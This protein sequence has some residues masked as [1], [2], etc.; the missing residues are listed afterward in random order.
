MHGNDM[1]N[2]IK[3]LKGDEML[4]AIETHKKRQA[5]ITQR[6]DR[7]KQ[8]YLGGLLDPRKTN[9]FLILRNISEK[10]WLINTIIG[11]IIDKT[12]PYL[13][14]MTAKSPRGFSIELK[15]PNEKMTK[16]NMKIASEIQEFFLKTTY[17]EINNDP[18]LSSQH[19]DDLI[20]YT[21]KV[22]R[23][24]LTIDQVAAEKLWT[25]KG[26]LLAFEAIDAGT[27]IRCTEE[28][29]NGNDA[30]RFVQM[31]NGIVE[32]QY[33]SKHIV[34]QFQ[35]PRTDIRY[36]GYGYSKIEQAIDLVVSLI[37]SFAYNAGAFTED[38]LPRGMLLLSGDAG[39]EEIEEIEDYLI[40]VM[41]PGGVGPAMG[42]W[43]IP[44]IPSG[45]EKGEIKWQPMGSTN[46]DMEYSQWTE[47]LYSAIGAL[48]GVDIESLGIKTQKSA[49]IIDSGSA[50]ARRYSDDKGIGNA[51]TFLERHFQHYLD[52]IDD[53][54][55]FV[56]HG[57]EKDDV[58]DRRDGIKHELETYK[59]INDILKE[60]D[61]PTVDYEWADVPGIHNPQVL[62]AYQGANQPEEQDEG[63]DWDDM[64]KSI[65]DTIKIII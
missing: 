50:D 57:F 48:Y 36:Y 5:R 13:R 60:N 14:P 51:L 19:E 4:K 31:I 25:R 64:N 52:I 43:G 29:Y 53:R 16:A 46:K 63:G 45:S 59:S 55:T 27:I 3:T 23:D 11:H 40:D 9:M 44:I 28:G 42:K 65:E 47:T 49:K 2:A 15:D 37:N 61:M 8:G 17:P 24:V 33:T 35:N 22:L 30:I 21:K 18:E 39:F 56:F 34:F 62:Q 38:K 12:I 10:A 1:R 41:G 7:L 20:H 6:Y 54:F 26:A 32:G 58:K